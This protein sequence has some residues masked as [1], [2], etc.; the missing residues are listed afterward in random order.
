MLVTT[1]FI[2]Q[3]DNNFIVCLN[4]FKPKKRKVSLLCFL[5]VFVHFVGEDSSL[6]H[7]KCFGF[8]NLKP[9]R[10]W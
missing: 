10:Y 4:S 7:A 9:V 8:L 3:C 5:M 2:N 6:T 1:S